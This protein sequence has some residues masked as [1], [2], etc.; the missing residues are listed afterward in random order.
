MGLGFNDVTRW[1]VMKN[2][3]LTKC[4]EYYKGYDMNEDG[5]LKLG[6]RTQN[7]HVQ[8]YFLDD[9]CLRGQLCEMGR[10][11]VWVVVVVDLV[12]CW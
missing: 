6:H 12:D 4:N 10:Q 3:F 11:D 9:F 8:E 5:I 7:V 1:N 2:I